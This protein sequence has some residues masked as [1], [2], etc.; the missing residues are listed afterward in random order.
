[1]AHQK[2][3]YIAG[4]TNSMVMKLDIHL[5][6]KPEKVDRSLDSFF[7]WVECRWLE[8][9]QFWEPPPYTKTGSP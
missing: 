2:Q 8:S 6:L 1:M 4:N 9:P 5:I 3:L 7:F